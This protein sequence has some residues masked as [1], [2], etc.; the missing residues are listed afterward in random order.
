[1][2][3]LQKSHTRRLQRSATLSLAALAI[4]ALL[5]VGHVPATAAE[6]EPDP[7][8]AKELAA[9]SDPSFE[10]VSSYYPAMKRPREVI[11]VKDHR[12]EF[13]IMPD[14]K[15]NF[16][17][18]RVDHWRGHIA[19]RSGN[20]F[21]TLG[22]PPVWFGR[23]E[24]GSPVKRLVDGYMPIV[25][26]DFEHDGLKYEQTA[27]AWSEG[28][29]ADTPLWAFVCLRVT[30]PGGEARKARICWHAD[31][32]A[33]KERKVR[34]VA[35]WQFQLE[36]GAEKT[37]YGKLPFLDGYEKAVESSAQEFDK[38][39]AEASA[40]WKEL[41]N[42]GIRI[43][44]P[45]ERVNN[46]YRAWLAYT[47]MNVDKI[48]G[49]YEPHDGSGFYEAIFGIMA[50][51][52]CNAMGLMG[53]PDEAQ[54]YLDS[55]EKLI[56]PEGLFFASFGAVDT[57]TLL[58]V[59]E[60]HYQLTGDKQ[61][62]QKELPTMIKMCN[63]IIN[64][65]K[66]VKA[67]QAKDSPYYG[68]IWFKV[69]VDNPKGGYNYVTD[70]ALCVGLDAAARALRAAGMA[71]EAARVQ[72]ESDAYRQ[73]VERS[74]RLCVTEQGGMRIL[75]VMP[76]T[77]R[78]LKRALYSAHGK[79]APG[80][81]Y[82]GHGYYSLFGSI[83]LE[84]K[85]LPA[86][87]E[88]FRLI[89]DLL[90]QRYGLLLGMCAFGA[91]GGID[92]AFTYGYWMNCLERDEVERVL[93][94]F[95]GSMAYGMS[96]GTWAGV[97]CTNII[98][99]SNART[100]PHLRSGTQQIRL[101][102]NMLVREEDDRLI[103]AQAAPQHWLADGQQ[104][105]VLDA[106]THFGKVSYTIDSHVAEGR[107]SIKLDPPTRKPPEVILL[108]LRHPGGKPI[109]AATADGTP[110]KQFESGAVTLTGLK[111]PTTIDVRY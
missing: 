98:S 77:H 79:A 50:A 60:Q 3:Y 43:K 17:P 21:F 22:D 36:P 29:S 42:K 28:M 83:I 16:T 35:S 63:W 96:R 86:S 110:I 99:G 81:G 47:F 105:A 68:L 75:P 31:H 15:L 65:R 49:K 48:D 23:G 5:T 70:T 100:L 87:H 51:K 20:V 13:I 1:M 94:G 19:S 101:L 52:F 89:T 90:E 88:S 26:A 92:H 71:D 9:K 37:V 85:F 40:F 80:K 103:L 108:L 4:V 74:M 95:Y 73:D 46:A 66:E 54:T 102:R 41:L 57:G 91:K 53:Y 45:E 69:G 8:G 6:P 7:L 109:K 76:E 61:W 67:E 27:V 39:F 32:G 111:G 10:S 104:V 107:I 14:G 55:L 38:H 82:S 106:P 62:L 18:S 24:S 34:E 12:D 44:V 56:S 58:W 97:E 72:N 78:Y 2:S 25:I 30:N 84:T 64:K 59:M 11:G 93:L 33:K